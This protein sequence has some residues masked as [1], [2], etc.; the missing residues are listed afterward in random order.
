MRPTIEKTRR[1]AERVR[2]IADLMA[3]EVGLTREDQERLRWT[4]MLHE[5]AKLGALFEDATLEEPLAAWLG[6]WAIRRSGGRADLS[7]RAS[8]A[9]A[10]TYDA[11]TSVR[12][13]KGPISHDAAEQDSTAWRGSIRPGGRP[14][15]R[16]DSRAATDHL[17]SVRIARTAPEQL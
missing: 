16:S 2:S 12:S 11:M 3:P 1:S 10:D 15:V 4:V 6:D 17:L 9:V 7:A 14:S 5:I 8:I 13:Y